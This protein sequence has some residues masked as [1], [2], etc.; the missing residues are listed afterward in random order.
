[1]FRKIYNLIRNNIAKTKIFW[2]FRHIIQP[3]VW[4]SY[5]ND[6]ENIRREF[7]SEFLNKHSLKSIFEFGC[8]SGPNFFSIKKHANEIYFFG[9][10]ISKKAI[11]FVKY[12]N[13]NQRYFF[14]HKLKEIEIINYLKINNLKTFDLAIFDRVLYMIS[15]AKIKLFFHKYSDYFKYIIIDDFHAKNS[16]WD[17]EKYIFSK[18]YEIILNDFNYKLIETKDSA[19][20]SSTA[21]KYAKRLI[22]KKEMT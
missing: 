9:Y 1:M 11:E 7:Y 22:F 3:D 21:K 17:K 19:L 8:A 13:Q 16:E 5:K 15:E 14:T 20:P 6:S 4:T 18:N 12:D 10:D 2:R